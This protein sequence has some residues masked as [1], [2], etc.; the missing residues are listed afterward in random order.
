MS[1]RS[2]AFSLGRIIIQEK[3]HRKLFGM[4]GSRSRGLGVVDGEDV[5]I[6]EG[7]ICRRKVETE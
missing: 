7:K 6:G 5:Y 2:V 3:I 4:V 1:A